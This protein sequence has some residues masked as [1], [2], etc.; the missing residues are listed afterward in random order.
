ML[1]TD[2]KS[3]SATSSKVTDMC[4]LFIVDFRA[5]EYWHFCQQ[6]KLH[7]CKYLLYNF[8][9]KCKMYEIKTI[10]PTETKHKLMQA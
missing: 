4:I 5:V 8:N 1:W 2:C 6:N 9:V 3:L 7:T 10:K